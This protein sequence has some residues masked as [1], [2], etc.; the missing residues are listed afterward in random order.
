M[1]EATPPGA[2]GPNYKFAVN[3][4]IV[5]HAVPTAK[6]EKPTT[7]APATEEDKAASGKKPSAGRRGLHSATAGY[8]NEKTDGMWSF[9]YVGD[10]RGF[11]VVIMLIWIA[12]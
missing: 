8:W 3:T 1:S 10:E 11:D 5:Q 9:K 7:S 4:T 2:A 12:I 6:V